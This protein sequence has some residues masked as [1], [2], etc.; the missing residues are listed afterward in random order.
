MSITQLASRAVAN[1]LAL[2][3]YV[4]INEMPPGTGIAQGVCACLKGLGGDVLGEDA[5][6]TAP[7]GSVPTM[8]AGP[9]DAPAMIPQMDASLLEV[10]LII[11]NLFPSSAAAAMVHLADPDLA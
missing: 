2:C 4:S 5:W 8:Q 1:V 11:R 7:A 9:A 3:V 6:R 10:G